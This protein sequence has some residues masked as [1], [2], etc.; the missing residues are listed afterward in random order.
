MDLEEIRKKE[1]LEMAQHIKGIYDI[2]KTKCSRCDAQTCMGC[3]FS[4]GEMRYWLHGVLDL[5]TK[6]DYEACLKIFNMDRD[7]FEKFME[8]EKR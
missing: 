4:P 5:M 3:V 1:N 6:Q 7:Q 2:M 8:A